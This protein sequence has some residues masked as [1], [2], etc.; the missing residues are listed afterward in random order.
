MQLQPQESSTLMPPSNGEFL[1]FLIA[2]SIKMINTMK[3]HSNWAY[4]S[5]EEY[6]NKE[7]VLFTFFS[8]LTRLNQASS[9]S[10][11]QASE[12]LNPY[13]KVIQGDDVPAT[14]TLTSLR[15]IHSLLSHDSFVQLEQN[16]EF[17]H[18][19]VFFLTS[20]QFETSDLTS[21]ELIIFEILK[22]FKLLLSNPSYCI[23][24]T[25]DMA[26]GNFSKSNC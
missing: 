10:Q 26:C 14:V 15:T 8:L 11:I 23:Y 7:T 20:C 12:V 19:L 4:Y 6:P 18:Y 2:Q 13:L 1:Q 21:A 9:P 25:D 22:I 3:R 24:I 5:Y 16:Q 17:F